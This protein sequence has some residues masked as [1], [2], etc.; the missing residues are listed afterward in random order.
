MHKCFS[1]FSQ[2]LAFTICSAELL[3]HTAIF[4][5]FLS[6]SFMWRLPFSLSFDN[7][8]HHCPL[9]HTYPG[10]WGNGTR[11][12]WWVGESEIGLV[13]WWRGVNLWK[14]F[15]PLHCT[16]CEKI[17]CHYCTTLFGGVCKCWQGSGT[18]QLVMRTEAAAIQIDTSL[19]L[20]VDFCN[21][22]RPPQAAKIRRTWLDSQPIVPLS[23]RSS[24]FFLPA[25]RNGGAAN[26][27]K[28]R[29]GAPTRSWPPLPRTSSNLLS[30]WARISHREEQAHPPHLSLSPHPLIE[31]QTSLIERSTSCLK[32]QKPPLLFLLRASIYLSIG[33]YGSLY[34]STRHLLPLSFHKTSQLST[35]NK[36]DLSF[37]FA[38]GPI[39]NRAWSV[40][41]SYKIFSWKT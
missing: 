41:L 26:R 32:E 23:A 19:Q 6:F 21:R 8:K 17:R 1:F 36:N 16:V 22:S 29:E 39:I 20:S 4:T 14:G 40:G 31:E 25:R 11:K 12:M 10:W 9:Y 27:E 24:K 5:S 35:E 18:K 13:L 15:W 38:W 37:V 28:E 30:W 7:L 2:N 34:G 33:G 3:F